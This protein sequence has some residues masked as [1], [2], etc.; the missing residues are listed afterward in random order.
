M[1]VKKWLG[2]LGTILLFAGINLFLYL[3]I[4][5][6]LANNFS[7]SDQLKMIDVGSFLPFE[8]ASDLARCGST[9]HFQK[10]D[11]LPVLDGAAALVPVYASVIENCYPE[12]CVT[13]EGGSFSDDNYY[14]EN[15]AP[16]SV[17]QYQ[18]TV[19]GFEALVDGSVDL[20]FTARP[21]QAQMEYAQQKGVDLEIVPIGTEAFVFIVNASNPVD[22]L[23]KAQIR[24]IYRGEITDWRTVGGVPG[25]IDTLT[26]VEG[27]GSQTMMEYF[28][29]NDMLHTRSPLAIF[30]RSI[31]YSFRYYVSG[32]VADDRV[33]MLA[34]D[35]VYPDTENIRNGNYPI[36]T[37][38]YVVYRKDDPNENVGR[39][40][41]WLR[42]EEGRTM[43]EACG[44]VGLA[45]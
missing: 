13:Y 17:M 39:L 42:S 3:K 35:G 15:F 44:Y 11:D 32:L 36:C 45:E 1:A 16:D 28:M 30:G 23:S 18:N 5:C 12:G 29:E 33:K 24:S 38:F 20:F 8:E 43:I 4:T 25:K 10:E 6:R 37:N 22:G 41:E 7:G 31:G 21:S 2:I 14:G 19:R 34:V 9:L 27:S 40:V 26:R